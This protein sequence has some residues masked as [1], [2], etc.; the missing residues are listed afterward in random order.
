MA[1]ARAVLQSEYPY[2]ISGRCINKEWF[3]IAMSRVWEVFC[4]ELSRTI[5]DHMLQVH[6][7]V[8][9]SNHF[10]LIASTPK[11]NIS[12]CM[13]QFR[14]RTSRKLTKEGNRLNETWFS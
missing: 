9:M 11:A 7:F 5:S 13:H 6:S 8:L 4:E 3:S 14:Q 12:Q 1:R 10:H 2:N